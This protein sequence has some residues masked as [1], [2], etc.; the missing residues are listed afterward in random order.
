RSGQEVHVR[1]AR[2]PSFRRHVSDA[3]DPQGQVALTRLDSYGLP[4]GLV[5]EPAR[6]VD[7]DVA[8]WQPSLAGPVD[9]RK[10]AL[11]QADVTANV[12]MPAVEVLRDVIV[13]AVRLVGNSFGRTE[14]NPARHRPSG[15][16]VDHADMHPVPA[17]FHQLQ[18]D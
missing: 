17:A 2:P 10:A 18:I 1:V 9:I 3:P 6:D 13:V 7:D 5:F 4:E 8:S 14:M 12:V 15:R 16:V 11:A